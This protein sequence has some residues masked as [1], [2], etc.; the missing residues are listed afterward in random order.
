[1]SYTIYTWNVDHGPG[2]RAGN[3]LI[4][5]LVVRS[6][7]TPVCMPEYPWAKY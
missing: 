1:M 5:R 7:A 6:L 4:K 2:S 3:L